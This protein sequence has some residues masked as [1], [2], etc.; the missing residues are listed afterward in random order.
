[1]PANTKRWWRRRR[2]SWSGANTS[3]GGVLLTSGTPFGYRAG[4]FLAWYHHGGGKEL[5]QAIYDRK[6]AHGNVLV[7]PVAMTASEPPGFFTEPVPDDPD[8]FD[9]S[10][11]AYRINLLGKKVMESAFP[12]LNVVT[13]A[14][15]VVPVDDFCTGVGSRARNSE[16]WPCTRTCFSMA[17]T[18]RMARMWLSA[19]SATSTCRAGSS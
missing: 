1:M 7:M 17:S 4:E 19:V 16:P 15:G 5:V 8:A 12:G 3:P 6:S 9:A 10:G 2:S 18:T 11:I 13:S 14:A